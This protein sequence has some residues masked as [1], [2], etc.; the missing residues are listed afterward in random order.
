[1]NGAGPEEGRKNAPH[2]SI[3][4]R[5][6]R[7]PPLAFRQL[8]YKVSIPYGSKYGVSHCAIQR[9]ILVSTAWGSHTT[10]ISQARSS[11][12][13]NMLKYSAFQGASSSEFQTSPTVCAAPRPGALRAAFQGSTRARS[14][15]GRGAAQALGFVGL[16]RGTALRNPGLLLASVAAAC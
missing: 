9:S 10:E 2:D 7:R 15:R 13:R 8:P 6:P 12:T 4:P 16:Q 11:L 1:M 3:K 5:Q 14:A